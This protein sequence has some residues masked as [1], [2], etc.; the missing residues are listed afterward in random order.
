[1]KDNHY[2]VSWNKEASAA[3]AKLFNIEPNQIFKRSKA[4]LSQNPYQ[5][6]NG[7]AKYP[8]FEFNGYYWVLINNVI[9]LYWIVESKQQVFVDACFFA[10]TEQ[11]HEIFWGI[12]PDDE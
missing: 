6:A 12:D 10:N 7:V 2:H 5:V 4:L 9:V 3:I 8:G 11:S 1:M